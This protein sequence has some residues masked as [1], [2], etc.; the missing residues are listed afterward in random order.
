MARKRLP[1]NPDDVI[2]TYLSGLGATET[3]KI[4][5]IQKHTVYR[6][7]R[8]AG[9]PTR[10]QSS[11]ASMR[12][13]RMSEADRIAF[14]TPMQNARSKSSGAELKRRSIGRYL[15]GYKT[16]LGEAEMVDWLS[17]RGLK[18]LHQFPIDIY[19]IDVAILPVAVEIHRNTGMPLVMPHL[20]KRTKHL[21][22]RGIHVIYV[23][24][25]PAHPL[26]KAAADDAVA[27]F[28]AAKTDPSTVGKY[29][30]IRGSGQFVAEGRG[31]LDKFAAKVT[32]KDTLGRLVE[33]Y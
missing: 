2:K 11:A 28:E 19:N 21:T 18:P 12:L 30:V 1:N 32:T 10:S 27:F 13:A 8:S 22:N 23:W 16:G 24:I 15:V 17:E 5:G 33:T 25:T 6:W 29:R 31:D 4:H 7:L 9:V 14:V 20:K 3:A 26:S